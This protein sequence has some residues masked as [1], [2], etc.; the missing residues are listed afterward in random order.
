[1]DVKV[2]ISTAT[3]NPMFRNLDGS[4]QVDHPMYNPLSSSAEGSDEI[5]FEM[6]DA[7]HTT[8]AGIY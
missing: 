8:G 1:M 6:I 5:L 3:A 7:R 4:A 2:N